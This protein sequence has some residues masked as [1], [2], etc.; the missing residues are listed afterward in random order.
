MVLLEA[1]IDRAHRG[2]G[3]LTLAYVN[4]D[5]V[6]QVNNR[7]GHAAGDALLRGVVAE[8]RTSLRSYDSIVRVGGDEFLCALPDSTPDDA[9]RRFQQISAALGRSQGFASIS[10]GCAALHPQDTLEQLTE[11]C[12]SA[13][14]EAKREHARHAR[15]TIVVADKEADVLALVRS[16]LEREGHR[17]LTAIDGQAALDLAGEVAPDLC[18]LAVMMPKLTGFEVLDA[19]RAAQSTRGTRVILLTS[20][21]RESDVV[22]GFESGADDYIIK[23]FSPRELRMRVRALLLR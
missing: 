22:R 18:V 7:R 1:E 16:V 3:C 8:M 6:K 9:R 17:V 15:A 10:V 12:D 5:G 13:L 23:P 2:N 19:L 14:G 21:S 4:V 11:R 20:R